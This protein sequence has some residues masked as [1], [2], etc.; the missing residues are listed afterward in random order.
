MKWAKIALIAVII[1]A[2]QF[3]PC[4]VG[5][6]ALEPPAQVTID[7]QGFYFSTGVAYPTNIE[8][9]GY[10]SRDKRM[11][12]NYSLKTD[13]NI[14]A[15]QK[16]K[17]DYTIDVSDTIGNKIA[18]KTSD[19]ILDERRISP[20][21]LSVVEVKNED[22]AFFSDLTAYFSLVITIKKVSVIP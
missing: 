6:A 11:F 17:F 12:L 18:S 16:A 8:I 15:P 21:G 14:E 22:L 9:T 1:T 5:T 3:V 13:L 4:F 10:N 20:A 2:M 7:G 19:Q